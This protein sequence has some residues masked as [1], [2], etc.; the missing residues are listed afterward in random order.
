MGDEQGGLGLAVSYNW[1]CR[2]CLEYFKSKNMWTTNIFRGGNWWQIL[3]KDPC[4]QRLMA[5]M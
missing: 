5:K 1:E 3:I 2:T 4:V